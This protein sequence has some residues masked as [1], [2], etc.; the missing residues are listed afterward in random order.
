MTM[1]RTTTS[2]GLGVSEAGLCLDFVNTEGVVRNDPPERLESLDLF[3]EWAVR[4]GLSDDDGVEVLRAATAE[5]P[6]GTIEAFLDRARELR[7]AI[8]R[9]FAAQ[10]ADERPAPEDLSILNRELAEALPRLR[11]VW[12]EGGV[13]WTFVR[14]GKRLEELLWPI[15]ASAADLLGS[16]LLSRVKECGGDT[17]SWMFID[18]SRNRSRRWC[19]MADCGNRAKAR[20]FYRRH[21]K[22]ESS[23]SPA[24]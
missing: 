3:F 21:V 12:E 1:V 2:S 9:I 18:E 5:V 10:S 17:C 14:A 16:E 22:G 20:R 24:G 6:P 23:D 8:Y 11:L 7:E 15:A 13:R 4:H 19:D